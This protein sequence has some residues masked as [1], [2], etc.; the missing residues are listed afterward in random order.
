MNIT[1]KERTKTV[2]YNGYKRMIIPA[3]MLIIARKIFHPLFDL[4]M[5]TLPRVNNP[6]INQYNPRNVIKRTVVI[7]GVARKAIPINSASMP[8]RRRIHQGK[9]SMSDQIFSGAFVSSSN[10]NTLR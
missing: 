1:K 8:Q 5:N 6:P 2:L 4:S 3:I 7:P 10:L 9:M